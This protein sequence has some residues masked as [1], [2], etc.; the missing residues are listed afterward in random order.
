MTNFNIVQLFDEVFELQEMRA[1]KMKIKLK[2]DKNY[3][4]PILV[5]AD[6]RRI[7]EVA[8]N[9]VVNSINYGRKQGTTIVGFMD[10]GDNWL[11]EVTDNGIGISERDLNRIFERFYRTDKSRSRDQGGTGLGL[12]IVKHIIEAHNQTINVRSA[13]DVGSSFAFTLKKA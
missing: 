13:M 7:I 2:F 1:K 4:K 10:M 5:K 3:E 11:I 8:N 9:L 6:R 12:A